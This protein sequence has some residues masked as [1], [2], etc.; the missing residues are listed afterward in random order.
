MPFGFQE[1]IIILIIILILFGA[2]KLPKLARGLGDAV[3]EFRK[4]A[5][6]EGGNS[7]GKEGKDIKS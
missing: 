2:D 7:E 5:K 3:K 4:A 1:L 6:D